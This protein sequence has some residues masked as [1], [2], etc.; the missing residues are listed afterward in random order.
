MG[1][2]LPHIAS[3]LESDPDAHPRPQRNNKPGTS[4][5]TPIPSHYHDLRQLEPEEDLI[6]M[7]SGP[8][9]PQILTEHFDASAHRLGRSPSESDRGLKMHVFKQ[10]CPSIDAGF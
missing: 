10:E 7:T 3:F 1:S 8:P 4:S 5:T 9:S 6:Q 2:R